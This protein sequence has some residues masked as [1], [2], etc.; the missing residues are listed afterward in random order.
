MSGNSITIKFSKL[1]YNKEPIFKAAYNFINN[2][3]F[4]IDS[5][6]DNYIVEISSK[7]DVLNDEI[8]NNFVDEVIVQSTR[9]QIMIETKNVRELILGRALAST[10]ITDVD[11][12]FID[13]KSLIAD[14]ILKDWFEVNDANN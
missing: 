6:K 12:G 5:D 3:H 11:T 10:M 14:D 9:Y 1:L 7:S 8:K 13:D 4:F 2:Y